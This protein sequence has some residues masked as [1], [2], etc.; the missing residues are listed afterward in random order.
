MAQQYAPNTMPPETRISSDA[1]HNPKIAIRLKLKY[2]Q[3]GSAKTASK[4]VGGNSGKTGK[5]F[6]S[7]QR[8]HGG[9][10]PTPEQKAASEAQSAAFQ[11]WRGSWNSGDIVPQPG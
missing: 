4:R 2:I 8:F 11:K 7:E 3:V 10:K 5:K 1:H 9:G 6:R